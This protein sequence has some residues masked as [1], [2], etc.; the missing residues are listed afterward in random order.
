MKKHSG[1][2]GIAVFIVL[3]VLYLF[4]P[5]IRYLFSGGK[6]IIVHEPSVM[7]FTAAS[8]NYDDYRSEDITDDYFDSEYCT[9]GYNDDGTVYHVWVDGKYKSVCIAG[10]Y[11][12]CPSTPA[13][14]VDGIE[15]KTDS[16]GFLDKKVFDFIYL[17]RNYSFW[18]DDISFEH[19]YKIKIRCKDK[20]ET[21]NLIIH[22]Y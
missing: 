3:G 8:H 18:I 7:S 2:I 10:T 13:V 4:A 1:T 16:S 22:R 11:Y 9:P 14:T 6:D 20:T 19:V 12:N 5:H 21:F 17:E 15:T